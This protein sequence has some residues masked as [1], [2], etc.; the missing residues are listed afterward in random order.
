MGAVQPLATRCNSRDTTV[1]TTQI[2]KAAFTERPVWS[3]F[4]SFVLRDLGAIVLLESARS[5]HPL[6][7]SSVNLA[8]ETLNL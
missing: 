5:G 8:I 1:Q 3:T 2:R 4:E 6:T 7:L